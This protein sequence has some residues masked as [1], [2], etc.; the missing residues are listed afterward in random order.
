MSI[1]VVTLISRAIELQYPLQAVLRSVA[2]IANEILVN[3]DLS[4]DDGTYDYLLNLQDKEYKNLSIVARRWNWDNHQGGSELAIQSKIAVDIARGDWILY[5]QADEILHEDDLADIKWLSGQDQFDGV[6]F[7]RL[8][9]WRDLQTIRLD[10][11]FSLLRMFR[12]GKGQVVGDGMN[13]A[14]LSPGRIW[15]YDEGSPRLFHYTR[16]GDAEIIAARIQNLDG[17]FHPEELVSRG[18]AYDWGLRDFD[19]YSRRTRPQLVA[20]DLAPYEG[21]HPTAYRQWLAET[22]VSVVPPGHP[23]YPK[24]YEAK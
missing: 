2:P 14:V 4:R 19:S 11:T 10:W 20:S 18:G 5:I 6:E 23:E 13:C 16:V 17:L 3:V 21:T 12:R 22:L 9:F 1:S 8:Y 15:P 7:R 24:P